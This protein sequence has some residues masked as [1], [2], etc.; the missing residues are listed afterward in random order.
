MVDL[1]KIVKDQGKDQD[2]IEFPVSEQDLVAIIKMVE[3]KLIGKKLGL[4]T[5]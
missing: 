2:D 1:L 3:E 5:T 4:G